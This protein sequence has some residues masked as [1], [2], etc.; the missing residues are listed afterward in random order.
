MAGLNEELDK[1][2]LDFITEVN[3]S[4]YWL[5]GVSFN[6]S[7]DYRYSLKLFRADLSDISDTLDANYIR[8]T[9]LNSKDKIKENYDAIRVMFYDE[10][11]E[12]LFSKK[13]K[14]L[15]Q[16]TIELDGKYYVFFQNER[17]EFSESYVKFIEEQVDSINFDIKQS[18]DQTE[19]EL[20]DSLVASGKY[21]QLHKDNVYINVKYC[22]EKADLM[23]DENIIM[24]KDQH[25][26]ADLVYLIKQTTTSLRF[27]NAGEIGENVFSGRN[28]CLW[29]LINRKKLTK[30]S[31]F[32]SFHLLGA[33]ND[34]KK[35]AIALNL[36]P[37]VWITL[38]E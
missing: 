30:L 18:T 20:I 25:Q 29:M 32:K 23:D 12:P 8:K 28:V 1:H 7:N 27:S 3:V 33:L 4:D 6:F 14:E 13:L 24:I 36:T 2:F 31:D 37:V 34:F 26:Q 16:I 11:D 35:A 38:N 21:T 5:T 19:T 15:L 9:I 10:N 22:I 17:V